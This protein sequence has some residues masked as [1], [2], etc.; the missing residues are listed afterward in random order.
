M[1]KNITGTNI[2]Y[3]EFVR[4]KGIII[5]IF[6]CLLFALILFSFTLGP[7]SISMREVWAILLGRIDGPDMELKARILL[8]IRL[9]R[10][11]MAVLAG[12]GLAVAGASMQAV[13]RNPLAS[14]F[15]LGLSSGAGFGA[16]LAIG[17]G[18]GI[19]GG[20]Y[21]VVGNAFIF[22]LISVFLVY[23][24]SRIRGSSP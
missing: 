22:A 4:R 24:I 13:L 3:K 11:I 21:M 8:M 10:N 2:S 17:L 6:V 23:G 19:W 9:P 5:F 12:M 7:A 16:A 15:T 18:F 14:S 20:Q 1:M